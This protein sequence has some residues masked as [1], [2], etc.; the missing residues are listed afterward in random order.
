MK[1]DVKSRTMTVSGTV[2]D[3]RTR[4][5]G[6]VVMPISGASAALAV[7]NDGGD[8]RMQFSIAASSPALSVTIPEDGVLFSDSVQITLSNATA[9]V[10]YG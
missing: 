9:V 2:Y 5:R 8:P 7:L 10:F 4:V 1:T 3:A 6:V